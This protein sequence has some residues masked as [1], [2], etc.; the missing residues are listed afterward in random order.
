MTATCY[1][2]ESILERQATDRLE[3]L[4]K[5]FAMFNDTYHIEIT[6]SVARHDSVALCVSVSV[7]H[8]KMSRILDELCRNNPLLHRGSVHY[9]EQ[10]IGEPINKWYTIAYSY[11]PYGELLL[12]H[13]P[14]VLLLL[15]Q[16]RTMKFKQNV[17]KT[18]HLYK[19]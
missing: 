7:Y 11:R 15:P 17:Q 1:E 6:D 13:P 5:Y 8:D 16:G 9:Q 12:M 2:I 19:Q 4:K 10:W 18:S 14:T 3:A